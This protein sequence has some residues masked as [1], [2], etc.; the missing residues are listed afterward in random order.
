[1]ARER[2]TGIGGVF[3]RAR[4]PEAL[5]AWYAEHVGVPVKADG[6][7]LFEESRTAHVW[8]PFR[9]D[10][11]YWPGEKQ[12]MVNFI[13]PDLDAMLAQLR[14]AGV[15]VDERVEDMEGVGR[16]GWA[17]DPEGNRFELWQP[18]AT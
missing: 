14:A 7:V 9:E 17:V 2:T 12:A 13:V 8:A 16:F 6:Y 5:V 18:A 10:T 3:F 1:V 15:E 11:D 4:D